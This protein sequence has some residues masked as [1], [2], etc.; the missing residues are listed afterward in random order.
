MLLW[1]RTP[2]PISGF[3]ISLPRPA[4]PRA[5]GRD[6]RMSRPAVPAQRARFSTRYAPN[7]AYRVKLT[8]RATRN[9]R[10]IFQR[11]DAEHSPRAG[12]WFNELEA[13]ILSLDEHPERC[14]VAP[15]KKTLRH[16]LFGRKPNVY[17]IIY[18]V[19]QR[20]RI[21]RILHI[22]NGARAPF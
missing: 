20:A 15:E 4:Q 1:C 18:G 8:A 2:K 21:V 17:R 22:R 12:A 13:A 7:M 9:L 10:Q 3:L 6:L 19:D 5:S 11:I 14:P 16:L